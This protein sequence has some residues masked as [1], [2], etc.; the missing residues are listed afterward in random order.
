MTGRVRRRPR[1]G[2]LLNFYQRRVTVRSAAKWNS[3]GTVPVDGS[4]IPFRG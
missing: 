3:T 1:L 4:S 2:G